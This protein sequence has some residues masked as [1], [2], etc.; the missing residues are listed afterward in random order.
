MLRCNRCTMTFR[1]DEPKYSVRPEQRTICAERGC[2][3][4]FCHVV[5]GRHN[6]RDPLRIFATQNREIPLHVVKVDAA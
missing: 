4:S 1:E 2:N 5:G 3:M 6:K